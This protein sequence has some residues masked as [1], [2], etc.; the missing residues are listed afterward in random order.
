[1]DLITDGWLNGRTTDGRVALMPVAQIGTA[2]VI[3]LAEPR[4]DFQVAVYQFLIGLLQLTFAPEDRD[5]WRERLQ[6][7]PTPAELEAAFEPVRSA[8]LLENPG[9]PAFLQDL[10]LTDSREASASDLLF[11]HGADVGQF[12]SKPRSEFGIC[13]R[14]AAVA[15]MNLQCHAPSGGR[16]TRTSLRG[17][18][19]ITTL[20]LPHDDQGTLWQRLWRNVIPTE[21]L[22][23]GPVTT[24]ADVLPW[25][26]PTRTSDQPGALSTTPADAHPLQAY[27]GMPR[28][29]RFD[30]ET[31][32]PGEC[33]V[34]GQ[35]HDRLLRQYHTRHGGVNYEG[36]WMHPLSPYTL[37]AKGEKPPIARKGQPGGLGYRDWLALT[38]G[39]GAD[40]VPAAVVTH[41]LNAGLGQEGVRLWASG[42]DFD[43]IKLRAWYDSM[44]PVSGVA[45]EVR[46]RFVNE[47]QAWLDAAGACAGFLSTRVK[48]A[49]NTSTADPVVRQDFWDQTEALFFECITELMSVIADP[50]AVTAT[51]RT[52]LRIVQ[53]EALRLFDEWAVRGP[54]E[55]LNLGRVVTARG[56]LDS[57][58]RRKKPMKVLWQFVR[59]TKEEQV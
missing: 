26:A 52:W 31:A 6:A 9:G 45:P 28:R 22:G 46:S 8:F 5:E 18:G 11:E 33:G 2:A 56:G 16:G 47:V 10:D 21:E 34:C 48:E 53:R 1:M 38:F 29:I 3:D 25:L 35:H 12:F 41:A 27:W 17:G 13:P 54:L 20:L 36:A 59:E 24:L 42:G 40:Q 51:R 58:L 49:W 4:P 15:L 39:V 19:P 55:V 7:P 32:S 43:N 23:Y 37:D 44:M 50:T 30:W 14:C 57:D